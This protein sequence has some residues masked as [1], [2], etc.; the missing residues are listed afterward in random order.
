MPLP[1][2]AAASTTAAHCSHGC[3][4]LDVYD[5]RLHQYQQ[6]NGASVWLA[7]G[8]EVA[9]SDTTAG[10]WSGAPLEPIGLRPHG[11][12]TKRIGMDGVIRKRHPGRRLRTRIEHAGSRLLSPRPAS[13]G[14][15][16]P[17]LT[18]TSYVPYQTSTVC[19]RSFKSPRPPASPNPQRSLWRLL[20]R[21][22]RC[23]SAGGA[24]AAIRGGSGQWWSHPTRPSERPASSK[25]RSDT[26]ST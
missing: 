1:S 17:I 25:T 23:L 2:R 9:A 18:Q 13:H 21:V 3:D 24:T 6:W 26:S 15:K 19:H 8:T 7:N 5:L 11:Q 10:L 14:C 16:T 20:G 4:G 22:R 12:S